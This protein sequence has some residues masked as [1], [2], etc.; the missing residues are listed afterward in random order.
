M[1]DISVTATSVK[2]GA[3]AIEGTGIAGATITAGQS[4]YED[5]NDGLMKLADCDLSAPAAKV[6]GIALHGAS[7]GQPIRYQKGGKVKIGGTAA[8]GTI[9]VASGNAG[10][11]APVG[12]LAANDWVTVIGV[13]DGDGGIDMPPGGPFASGHMIPA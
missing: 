5:A 11:V 7:A 9:Y 10:G 13:G 3:G 6:R 4:I 8:A 2:A 12:D 1:T